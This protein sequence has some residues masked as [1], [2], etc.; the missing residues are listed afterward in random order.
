MISDEDLTTIQQMITVAVNAGIQTHNHLGTDSPEI[1]G[2]NLISAPTAKIN[3]IVGTVAGTPSTGGSAVLSTS[4]ATIINSLITKTNALIVMGN[5][6][7]AALKTLG[8]T[9]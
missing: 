7:Q 4:D 3:P 2:S 8:F 1:S 9:F 5:K 6:I